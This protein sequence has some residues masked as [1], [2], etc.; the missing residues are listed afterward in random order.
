MGVDPLQRVC[1]SP[2][3]IERGEHL[4]LPNR[5]AAGTD[6]GIDAATVLTRCQIAQGEV[7]LGARQRAFTDPLQKACEALRHVAECMPEDVCRPAVANDLGEARRDQ[8]AVGLK[9]AVLLMGC[10]GAE[11]SLPPRRSSGQN[12]REGSAHL[13]IQPHQHL[14]RPAEEALT[15]R[16]APKGR[17]LSLPDWGPLGTQPNAIFWFQRKTWRGRTGCGGVRW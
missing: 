15:H 1:M 14:G 10:E 11:D 8:F 3:R 12:A 6:Q 9:S 16:F 17:C 13:V 2:A 5:N 7:V 4:Q